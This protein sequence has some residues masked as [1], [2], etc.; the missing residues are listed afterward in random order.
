[1]LLSL[2]G[3]DRKTGGRKK[4]TVNADGFDVRKP[5]FNVFLMLY[6]GV[7]T[8]IRGFK[9]AV[10]TSFNKGIALRNNSASFNPNVAGKLTAKL[11]SIYI[12]IVQIS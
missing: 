8:L 9:F 1:M 4:P 2:A 5:L 3:D 6:T 12:M 11:I 10:S 7:M